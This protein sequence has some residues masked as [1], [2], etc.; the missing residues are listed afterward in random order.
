[1]STYSLRI[2]NLLGYDSKR[3]RRLCTATAEKTLQAKLL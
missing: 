2:I 1:M 3:N